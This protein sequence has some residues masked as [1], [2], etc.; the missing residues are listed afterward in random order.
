MVTFDNDPDG[1]LTKRDAR[2]CRRLSIDQL[3]F[4]NCLILQGDSGPEIR[5]RT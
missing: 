1:F 2:A 3:V 4:L 5:I